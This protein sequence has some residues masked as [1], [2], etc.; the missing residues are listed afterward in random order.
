MTNKPETARQFTAFK[1]EPKQHWVSEIVSPKGRQ[2]LFAFGSAQ[3]GRWRRFELYSGHRG[4]VG[5]R[6][7]PEM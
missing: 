4:V 2:V 6:N 3:N 7:R 5:S 1:N